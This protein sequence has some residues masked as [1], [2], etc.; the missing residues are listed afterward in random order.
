V[1]ISSLI[2]RDIVTGRA[3]TPAGNAKISRRAFISFLTV[4]GAALVVGSYGIFHWDSVEAIYNETVA[5]KL[6]SS[7][8]YERHWVDMMAIDIFVQT[9]GIGV[10]LGSH[11]PNSLIMTIVS[12]TGIFGTIALGTFF[13]YLLMPGRLSGIPQ[14]ADL[15]HISPFQAMLWG[16]LLVHIFSNPNLSMGLLWISS[17]SVLGLLAALRLERTTRLATSVGANGVDI[18]RYRG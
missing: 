18:G 9:G 8:F 4:L 2:L 12:N 15:K 5:E 3:L 17:G 7:S 11:K 13:Y 10:G 16:L 6:Q 1:V 14:R